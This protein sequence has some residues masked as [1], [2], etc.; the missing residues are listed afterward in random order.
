MFLTGLVTMRLCCFTLVS[1]SHL[2]CTSLCERTGSS[3]QELSVRRAGAAI[4][5]PPAPPDIDVG[6]K[7]EPL[8]AQCLVEYTGRDGSAKGETWLFHMDAAFEDEARAEKKP[9]FPRLL[10]KSSHIWGRSTAVRCS[11][12]ETVEE[13]VGPCAECIRLF[14]GGTYGGGVIVPAFDYKDPTKTVWEPKECL[15]LRALQQPPVGDDISYTESGG[16]GMPGH[17]QRMSTFCRTAT[18]PGFA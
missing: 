15:G 3:R 2:R 6:R 9:S 4:A 11:P 8:F 1:P 17:E 7:G 18:F 10:K 12:L 16:G 14:V 13:V 5:E